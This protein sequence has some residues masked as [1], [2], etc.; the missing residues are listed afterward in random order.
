VIDVVANQRYGNPF[1][2]GE[3]VLKADWIM[4]AYALLLTPDA[5]R[6]AYALR[7]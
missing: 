1:V 5:K 7:V 4:P 6:I 3:L 2:S